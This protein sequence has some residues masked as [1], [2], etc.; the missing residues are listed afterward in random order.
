MTKRKPYTKPVVAPAS[1]EEILALLA[2]ANLAT[3]PIP[4]ELAGR[5]RELSLLA[6]ALDALR[7][8]GGDLALEGKIRRRVLAIARSL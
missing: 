6:A 4:T 5:A 1:E 8:R 7:R 2:R 3:D